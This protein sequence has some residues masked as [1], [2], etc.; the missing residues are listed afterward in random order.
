MHNDEMKEGKNKGGCGKRTEK[1]Q[2]NKMRSAKN[3]R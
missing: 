2:R 3:K 1:K